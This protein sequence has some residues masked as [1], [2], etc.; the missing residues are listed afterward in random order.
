M[1]SIDKSLIMSKKLKPRYS[2]KKSNEFWNTIN[3]IPNSSVADNAYLLGCV[4]REFEEDIL[5]RINNCI[6]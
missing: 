2:G 5:E 1:E 6:E 3:S 4:L